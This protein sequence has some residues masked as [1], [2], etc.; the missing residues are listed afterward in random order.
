MLTVPSKTRAKIEEGEASA[1]AVLRKLPCSITLKKLGGVEEK[2][3][4]FG[5]TA[6]VQRYSV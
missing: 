1:K 4:C 3:I 5:V 2:R 6:G